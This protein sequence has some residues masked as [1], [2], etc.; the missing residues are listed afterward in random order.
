MD[1]DQKNYGNVEYEKIAVAVAADGG[2]TA[3]DHTTDIDHTLIIGITQV[4]S[5]ASAIPN[6]TIELDIDGFE[7]FP[8]GFESKLIAT[9]Q[10]VPPNDKYLNY[11]NREIK[12]VRIKGTFTDGGA[13]GVGFAAYTANIYLMVRTNKF[14]EEG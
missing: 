13:L 3:I 8:A 12:Q 5:N 2:T 14:E 7:V 6:S 11:I 9:G 1:N 10:E 4:F